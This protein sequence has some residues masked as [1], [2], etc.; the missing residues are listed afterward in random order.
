M[1]WIADRPTREGYYWH[2]R[3]RGDAKV[4]WVARTSDSVWRWD[5]VEV[6]DHGSVDDPGPGMHEWSGPLSEPE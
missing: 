1:K 3:D 2:R 6:N 4:V 5:G